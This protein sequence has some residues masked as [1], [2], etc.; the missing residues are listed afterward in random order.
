MNPTVVEHVAA[1][2]QLTDVIV[3]TLNPETTVAGLHKD[4]AAIG[5]PI[6]AA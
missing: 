2:R 3:Q 4:I 1:H 6:A 5:Y